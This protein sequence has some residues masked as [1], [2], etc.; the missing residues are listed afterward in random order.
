[1]VLHVRLS[2]ITQQIHQ[3][4][5]VVGFKQWTL[6]NEDHTTTFH[7]LFLFELMSYLFTCGI[8]F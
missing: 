5:T 1:M 7:L 3:T 6:C 8:R 2:G 4:K